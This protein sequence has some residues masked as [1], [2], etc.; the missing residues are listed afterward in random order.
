M[1]WKHS[2]R[3]YVFWALAFE[4]GLHCRRQQAGGSSVQRPPQTTFE[5]LDYRLSPEAFQRALDALRRYRTAWLDYLAWPLIRTMV[6]L[7]MTW[8]L[9]W[10]T[11]HAA[12]FRKL[13]RFQ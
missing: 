7:Q 12:A 5:M 6:R 13:L 11:Y 1:R 2:I 4:V 9:T 3:R 8:P 10:A